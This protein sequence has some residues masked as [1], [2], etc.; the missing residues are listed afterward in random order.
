MEVIEAMK[1]Q[2]LAKQSGL[3]PFVPKKEPNLNAKL[4]MKLK[5][6]FSKEQKSAEEYT[7]RSVRK[8]V[9]ISAAPVPA[10]RS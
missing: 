4:K 1:L 7:Y 2:M 9:T 5:Q 6:R 3:R 8:K 10:G